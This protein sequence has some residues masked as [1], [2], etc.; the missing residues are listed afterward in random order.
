M[1]TRSESPYLCHVFVCTNDRHG[2]RKSCADGDSYSMRMSLKQEIHSRGWRGRVRVSQSGCLGLC[3]TG[4]NVLLYPQ[5]LWYS[6]VTSE[7]F[8][9]IMAHIERIVEASDK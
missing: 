3:D 7:D 9:E 1:A 4:P 5:Q 8:G 2:K 6:D